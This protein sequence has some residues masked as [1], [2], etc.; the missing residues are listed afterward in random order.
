MSGKSL[1]A[2]LLTHFEELEKSGD[3][4]LWRDGG[5]AFVTFETGT[6]TENWPLESVVWKLRVSQICHTLTGKILTDQNCKDVLNNLKGWALLQ[7]PHYQASYRVGRHKDSIYI[8]LADRRWQFVKVTESGWSIENRSPVRF[9][10]SHHTKP[11]PIPTEGGSQKDLHKYFN[12]AGEEDL[13]LMIAF[14]VQALYPEGPYPVLSLSGEQ[15]SAKTTA[16]RI[17]ISLIDPK[18]APL[19]TMPSNERDLML[20]ALNSRLLAFDNVSNI[21]P[22]MSDAFCRIS[23]GGGLSTRQLYTDSEQIVF[24]AQRPIVL[25]GINEAARRG[26]LVDRT[27][28]V[29]L[30]RIPPSRRISEAELDDDFERNAPKLFGFILDTLSGSLKYRNSI[31]LHEPPR[32]IDFAITGEAVTKTLG[33]EEGSFLKAFSGS[34]TDSNMDILDA[35]P[36][37]DPVRKL[38][39][40]K[41][42]WTGKSN[43]LISELEYDLSDEVKRRKDW[44]KDAARMGRTMRTLAPSFRAEDISVDFDTPSRRYITISK[45][46]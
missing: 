46:E 5:K 10:R 25:T 44:P 11:L 18:M 16:A 22:A 19:R 15:G 3:V 12:V 43:D 26:D 6:H 37:G 7:G 34:Q 38:I 35:S 40:D 9:W 30:Q 27:V 33:M 39:S 20:D 23:S 21:R 41:G 36:I 42:T 28:S 13:L 32:M 29:K 4:E 31:F 1:V 45:I 17:L 2:T 8:D 14:M 24:E